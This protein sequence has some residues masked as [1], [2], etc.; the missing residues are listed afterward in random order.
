MDVLKIG[1]G[2]AYV[3]L[4]L[5]KRVAACATAGVVPVPR[6]ARCWRSRWPRA[7]S[8]ALRRWAAA[9]GIDALE[10]SNGL[11]WLAPGQQRALVAEPRADFVVLAEAGVKDAAVPV[12]SAEWAEEMNAD[13]A[14]GAPGSS[15][16]AGSRARSGCTHPDGRG[17]RTRSSGSWRRASPSTG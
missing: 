2:I 11:G 9:A 1:W 16:R 4:P 7:R 6:R 8:T 3:D 5:K 13:L 17:P 12:A 14:A 10:V 15:P